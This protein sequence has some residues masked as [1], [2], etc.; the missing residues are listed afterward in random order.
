M[1]RVAT[2]YVSFDG[3]FFDSKCEC[4]QYETAYELE[5]TLLS[6][7]RGYNV[8]GIITDEDLIHLIKTFIVTERTAIQEFY[9]ARPIIED[10]PGSS[11]ANTPRNEDL[12][13]A[14]SDIEEDDPEVRSDATDSKVASKQGEG[15]F[16]GTRKAT[17][18]GKA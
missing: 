12:R 15:S 7:F 17:K 8:S 1:A 2:G 16:K 4:E 18:S 6:V 9:D 3:K 11:D 14:S 10:D 5:T 13:S